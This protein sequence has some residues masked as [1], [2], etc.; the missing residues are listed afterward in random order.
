MRSLSISVSFSRTTS[1]TRRP[2]AY[3]G[4]QEDTVPGILRLC[5]QALKFLNA[6]DLGE[7]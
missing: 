4:H 2:A 6:Q 3:A 5:E 7:L 1:P